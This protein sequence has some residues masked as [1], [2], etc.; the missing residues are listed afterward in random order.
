MGRGVAS[1]PPTDKTTPMGGAGSQDHGRSNTT[2]QGG[3]GRSVSHPR[4]MQE[5]VGAQPLCQEGDLPS[6][7]MPSVP[8]PAA[9]EGTQPQRGDRPRF[10][11]RD[12]T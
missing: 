3:G 11:L 10:A 6:G 4:G 8:P 7:S 9:P 12:P 1:D 2:W 5:K